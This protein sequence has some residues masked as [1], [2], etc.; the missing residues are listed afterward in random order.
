MSDPYEELGRQLRA[1]NDPYQKLGAFFQMHPADGPDQQPENVGASVADAIHSIV[2]MVADH[3]SPSS[4]PSSSPDEPSASPSDGD[5]QP[6]D[7]QNPLGQQQQLPDFLKPPPPPKIEN[8]W[9]K[10]LK[11][12]PSIED[13][14][15]I[16]QK[17]DAPTQDKP[18]GPNRL[19]ITEAELKKMWPD[20]K[21][22][23]LKAFLDHQDEI[24][25]KYGITTVKRLAQFMGQITVE[26]GGGSGMTENFNY[27]PDRLRDISGFKEHMTPEEI[28]LYTRNASHPANQKML[29]EKGYGWRMGNVP[30]SGDGFKFRGRGFIQTTGR[31]AY[32][33]RSKDFG[34]DLQKNP[35]AIND[36]AHVLE[37]AAKEFA[38]YN[39]NAVKDPAKRRKS[40]LELSDVGDT[41]GVTTWV[42]GGDN[43]LGER[44]EKYG[45]WLKLLTNPKRTKTK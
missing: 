4:S 36:P 29:A 22:W 34:V 25:P 16:P 31:G 32:A 28:D 24:L 2:S 37:Y 6:S 35:D 12:G 30:G 41:R 20:A 15:G 21:P 11:P 3:V 1:A 17:K 23:A 45:A 38:G 42:N 8:P 9:D 27:T 19:H 44:I 14:L 40:A 5:Q 39:D 26:T 7:Q 43:Q 10:F 18:K 13:L 33:E